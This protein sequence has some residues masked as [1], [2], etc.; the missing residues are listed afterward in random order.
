M[1]G[2][3]GMKMGVIKK[4][5]DQKLYECP[6]CQKGMQKMVPKLPIKPQS[7]FFHQRR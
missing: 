7:F 1:R 5:Q 2:F 3:E 6:L 4:I